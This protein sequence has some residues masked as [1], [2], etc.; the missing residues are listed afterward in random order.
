M[1]QS[2]M[3]VCICVES[4]FDHGHLSSISHDQSSHINIIYIHYILTYTYIYTKHLTTVNHPWPIKININ[5]KPFIYPES[6]K[7]SEQQLRSSI[8]D[9][10]VRK[11]T[12]GFRLAVSSGHPSFAFS[13]AAQGQCKSVACIKRLRQVKLVAEEYC[14]E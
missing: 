14:I 4:I 12:S 6:V 9:S 7:T 5:M 10:S 13:L 8:D 11:E 2:R 3:C 1:L